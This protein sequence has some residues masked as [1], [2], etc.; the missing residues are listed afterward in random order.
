MKDLDLDPKQKAILDAAWT[1]FA[2][3]GFR[4]TSMDDIARGAGMS[5][6][7]LYLHYRNKDDIFQTLVRHCYDKCSAALAA[8]LTRDGPVPEVLE[9]AILAQG[10]IVVRPMLSSAH[11]MELMEAG[12]SSSSKLVHDGEARLRKIYAD[13]L[14]HHVKA[15]AVTLPGSTEEMAALIT[16]SLKGAKATAGSYD[17]YCRS[18]KMLAAVFGAGIARSTR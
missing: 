12:T 15:G 5:R 18:V 14:A 7:A 2:T 10:E 3:Y 8:A 17:D 1:A 6:A 4:K 9:A 11:G 16:S 13:W